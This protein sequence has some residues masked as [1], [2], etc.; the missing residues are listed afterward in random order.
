MTQQ[1]QFLGEEA[2]LGPEKRISILSA[3]LAS[4]VS[5]LGGTDQGPL[6]IIEASPALEVF[7]DE[8]LSETVRHG[9]ETRPIPDYHGMSA[10][11]ACDAIQAA[12]AS[13][14]AIGRFPVLLGGEHTVTAPAVRA[15]LETYPDL[16]VVQIDAHLD[17]RDRYEDNPHSHACVMRRLDEMGVPFT[18]IGMRSFS[19]EEYQLVRER[20]WRPFFMSRIHAEA[21]WIEQVC[22]GINGPVYLTVDVDGL[23]P[24]IMPATGTP[25]PD[26][27]SWR[28]TI[29]L[30]RALTAHHR[31]VAM[32]FVEF[33]PRPGAEHAAFTVAKLIYRALGYVFGGPA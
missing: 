30:L 5:W 13:E 12:V 21:D 11:Q 28:Q 2:D 29:A 4:T 7:D 18:Q 25:E 23:D 17:L 8:L 32:D 6:A 14:L 15:C 24:S 3:P 33:S 20:G 31:L 9:I 1:L 26:G 27:L 22:R 16:H 19:Q 10:N